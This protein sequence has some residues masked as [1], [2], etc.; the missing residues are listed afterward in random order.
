M[1][2]RYDRRERDHL[3][4][5]SLEFRGGGYGVGNV[6]KQ[7]WNEAEGHLAHDVHRVSG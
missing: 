2:Y 3:S 1:P 4:L 7:F 5:L 6:L